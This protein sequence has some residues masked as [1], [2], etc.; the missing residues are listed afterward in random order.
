VLSWPSADGEESPFFFAGQDAFAS[1]FISLRDERLSTLE[2]RTRHKTLA[3]CE[4]K[5][6]T[7]QRQRSMHIRQASL[8]NH[9]VLSVLV[10]SRDRNLQ[11]LELELFKI[12]IPDC[13]EALAPEVGAQ[14]FQMAT[15]ITIGAQSHYFAI[16][17][18]NGRLKPSLLVDAR[19]LIEPHPV[20][21]HAGRPVT[22]KVLD[23]FPDQ[24]LAISLGLDLLLPT[25]LLA[26]LVVPIK[27]SDP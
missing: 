7:E 4:S 27:T 9:D 1:R 13:A 21:F 2:W 5:H 14:D 25:P 12:V 22:R 18:I 8:P 3:F 6:L 23:P 20:A 19:E 10:G 16:A 26:R 24:V 11:S 17:A 15:K